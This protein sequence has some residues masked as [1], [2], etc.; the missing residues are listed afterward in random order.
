MKGR[1]IVLGMDADE[2]MTFR[3][4]VSLSR[5]AKGSNQPQ[6]SIRAALGLISQYDGLVD[7]GWIY[8]TFR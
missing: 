6:K 5:T 1:G 2:L 3:S 4:L 7:E 8:I